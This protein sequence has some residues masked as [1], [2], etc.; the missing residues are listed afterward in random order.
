[1]FEVFRWLYRSTPDGEISIV[2]YTIINIDE[3]FFHR[4]LKSR[5]ADK[6]TNYRFFLDETIGNVTR[7]YFL[8]FFKQLLRRNNNF[9]NLK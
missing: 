5:F 9:S 1:M 7:Y 2:S 6:Q 4:N 3:T 8:L